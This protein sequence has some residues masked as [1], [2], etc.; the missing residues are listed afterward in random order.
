[1]VSD[2]GW[3]F[4]EIV[5]GLRLPF[6]DWRRSIPRTSS[7]E[8]ARSKS[9]GVSIPDTPDIEWVKDLG[10]VGSIRSFGVLAVSAAG[11]REFKVLRTAL[12]EG[13]G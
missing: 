4:E 3:N 1:M 2:M 5:D 7:M 8:T 9:G 13:R 6:V 11:R 10:V 12:S